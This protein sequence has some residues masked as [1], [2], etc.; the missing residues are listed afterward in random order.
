MQ[1]SSEY[2]AWQRSLVKAEL[3]YIEPI[4]EDRLP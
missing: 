3:V 1:A 2:V 4:K